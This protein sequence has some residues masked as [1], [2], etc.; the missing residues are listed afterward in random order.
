MHGKGASPGINALYWLSRLAWTQGK[1][2]GRLLWELDLQAEVRTA[3]GD[4][5][6]VEDIERSKRSE[7]IA[8]LKATD[9]GYKPCM[10]RLSS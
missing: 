1:S 8:L 3:K 10:I 7:H 9:R 6:L 4:V 2:E 5:K